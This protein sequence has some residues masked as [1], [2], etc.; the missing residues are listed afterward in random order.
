M[1]GD[2]LPIPWLTLELTESTLMRDPKGAIEVLSR[3]RGD[4][5]LKISVDDFG[6]G[7]SSLA[8][9]RRLPLNEIKIDRK[10]VKDMVTS[11]EDAAIV[12]LVIDLGYNLGLQVIAEG[13][14]DRET[15]DLLASL[16][17]DQAQGY[18]ISR[19]IP[20]DDLATWATSTRSP[21]PPL[22]GPPGSSA[23]APC[24]TAEGQSPCRAEALPAGSR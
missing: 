23:L 19:P 7:Y 9:L 6:V 3:L 21:S 11:A 20:A 2:D 8:Y 12:K 16:G 1:G 13:V 10:F 5:G 14:E 18:F 4:L 17:C 15:L 22:R 24:T